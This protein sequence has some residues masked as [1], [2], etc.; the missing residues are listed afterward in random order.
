[1]R[2][3]SGKARG[4]KLKALQGLNTRPTSDR[5]K[6]SLFNIIA[7]L[8]HEA[9]VLD[10]FSGTGN[11]AIESLSRNASFAYLVD[12]YK[13]AIEII[14][15]NIDK[16]RFNEKVH[17]LNEDVLIA[18]KKIGNANNI[19]FDIRINKRLKLPILVYWIKKELY[20]TIGLY[21]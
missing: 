17:I 6:E 3:I 4:L 13:P 18:I 12:N 9:K 20:I 21:Y 2:I 15:E 1:M 5:V 11:L 8:L 14:K 10:L 19:K 7:P 16:A